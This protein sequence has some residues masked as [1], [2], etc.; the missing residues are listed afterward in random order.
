M[1]ILYFISVVFLVFSFLVLKKSE[2][3]QSFI[4]WLAIGI[5][6]LY[7]YNILIGMAI[8]MLGI[9]LSM[10]LL[11]IFNAVFGILMSFK[12]F[13]KKEYQKYYF[14]KIQV[15]G[16][17]LIAIVFGVMF[18]KDLYIFSGDVT[19]FAVDS[20]IHYRA[21]KHYSDYQRIF[22]NIEDRS[23]FNFNVM[24]PGA[25]INDGIF[26]R[27]M[28]SICNIDY[29]YL[30]QMFE[31][32]TLFASGLAFY[33]FF[34]DKMKDKKSLIGSLIL[35]VLYIY[36]YPYNSWIY[37]FSY[38]S[39][40]IVM[41]A[42]L[43][44]VVDMMFSD[45]EVSKKYV[46]PLIGLLGFGLIFSYCLFIP[47]IFAAICIYVFIKELK[48]EKKFIGL[49]GKNTLIVTGMLLFVTA[50]GIAYLF[51]PTFYIEGQTNLVSALKIDGAIYSEKYKNFI[52]YIPF[53]IIYAFDL[54]KRIKD[55]KI[56]YFDVFSVT[57]ILYL[58]LLYVGMVLGKVA[59][60]YMLKNYF[61]IW[62]VVLGVAVDIMNNYSNEKLFRIDF[63]I[64]LL[65]FPLLVLKGWSSDRI[66]RAYLIIVL[67]FY[68]VFPALYEKMNTRHLE[69]KSWYK[70]IKKNGY[71]VTAFAYI[72]I[73]G[74]FVT[75]W[76]WLKSGHII[77]EEVKHALPN[78][79]GIY[80]LENWENRK[81]IQLNN[82][83]NSNELKHTNY[84]KE[85]LDDMTVENTELISE[86]YYTRIWAT[87]TL[88]FS[89][90]EIPYQ[91][92]IQDINIYT[93]EDAINDTEKKYIVQVVSKDKTKMDEYNEK[94]EKVRANPQ[95][96]IL[97]ENENGFV[98]EIIR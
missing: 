14:D 31:T 30:Y 7:A 82:D 56:R 26:M 54:L 55:K 12:F 94:M 9:R 28:S 88:E 50:C 21:A 86:G 93:V 13:T 63:I 15:V 98:A 71:R 37:G 81:L 85:N 18:V 19:H 96:K 2:K 36:G 11:I 10:G 83:F 24:Q 49:F 89:S 61:I 16:L 95:I 72:L 39:V 91:N 92:V 1:V 4:K 48:A 23:F 97:T 62:M 57:M 76:V 64:M 74:V 17:V 32:I 79:V 45:E 58:C 38:L 40:G 22:I 34:V 33:A 52:V 53:A 43:I 5:T 75:S 87:A 69:G 68:V 25:Y 90:D 20:A 66:F 77:G 29:A 42:A 6:S 47:A 73:W 78:L 41:I 46:I 70:Y 60:Y 67:V 80:Y 3:K 59:P 8:G 35:F 51:I 44:P 27:A 84:A 65:L